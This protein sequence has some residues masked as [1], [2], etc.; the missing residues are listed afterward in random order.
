MIVRSL[1]FALCVIAVGCGGKL[2]GAEPSDGGADG[3]IAP[4]PDSDTPVEPPPTGIL[5]SNVDLLFVID[6]SISM[7]DKQG[8]LARA[9]PR[10][11][12][13]LTTTSGDRAPA[14]LHVG[15]IT[16]SLGSHGTS[17]CAPEIT[18]RANNDHARLLPRSGEG[19]GTGFA[20][21]SA[22]SVST[23]ACP[24]PTESSFLSWVYTGPDTEPGPAT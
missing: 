11:I 12:A 22:G 3:P 14:S 2:T 9:I 19:G 1:C 8:Q 10:L 24:S 5:T 15:V 18:N 20:L 16:S 4:W 7:A 21:D 6:N 23:A 17:A 13:D